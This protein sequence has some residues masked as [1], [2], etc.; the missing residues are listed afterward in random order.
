MANLVSTLDGFA[1]AAAPANGL[2]LADLTPMASVVVRTRNSLYRIFM[3]EPPGA[4]LLQ[5]GRFFPER[6]HAHLS[7]SSLGGSALKMDWIGV[8]FNMEIVGPGGPVVT[9]PVRS[10]EVQPEDSGARF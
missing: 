7:G 4:I 5:G 2:S 3:L 8:G 9:S 1:R 6:T 10:I